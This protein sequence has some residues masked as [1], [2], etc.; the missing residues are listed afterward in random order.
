MFSSKKCKKPNEERVVL[1]CQK[2]VADYR[3]LVTAESLDLVQSSFEKNI[4]L[5]SERINFH[6]P[7]INETIGKASND[8]K[9][10]HFAHYFPESMDKTLRLGTVMRMMFSQMEQKL[11]NVAPEHRSEV[12]HQMFSRLLNDASSQNRKF[13]I[14]IFCISL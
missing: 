2:L 5:A 7:P 12:F 3:F 1:N 11:E 14:I 9:F 13:I 6:G 4:H 10:S 8:S